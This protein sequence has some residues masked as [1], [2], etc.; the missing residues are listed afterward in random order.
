MRRSNIPRILFLATLLTPIPAM[1]IEEPRFELLRTIGSIEI[2][3]VEPHLVAETVLDEGDFDRAGNEGFRRLAGYIFGGNQVAAP[4]GGSREIARTAPVAQRPAA[5]SQRIAMTA[6]VAQ[7]EAGQ[8]WIVA[9]TMP[10]GWTLAT[11]PVPNDPCITL[12]E[13]PAR[14]VAALR[15]SGAWSEERFASRIAELMAGVRAAGLTAIH[16]PE[17]AR[18]DPPF[19][20]WFLRRNEVLVE[21]DASGAP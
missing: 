19:M 3:K 12:R 13:V 2:R 14:T 1:A 7:R 16:E 21:I 11:L 17:T 15:F 8:G 20:P 4:A 18:Y 6:P 5:A 9:F 10:S